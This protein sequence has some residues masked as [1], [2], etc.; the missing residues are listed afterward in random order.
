MWRRT[1]KAA[2]F[3]NLSPA[4]SLA[5]QSLAGQSLAGIQNYRAKR[6]ALARFP[7]GKLLTVYCRASGL[8]VEH[9]VKIVFRLG[10][11][12]LAR[13]DPAAHGNAGLMHGL[14]IARD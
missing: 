4:K 10:Q 3:A 12:G 11:V 13:L 8:V 9:I 2:E 1:G 7:T 5:G 6:L 14:G